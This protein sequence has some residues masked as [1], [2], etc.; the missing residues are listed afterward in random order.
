M[1]RSRTLSI[2]ALLVA[3]VG[4]GAIGFFMGRAQPAVQT[5]GERAVLY[6]YDPMAPDTHFDKPGK[7]PFMDMDLV[8]RYADERDAASGVSIAPGVV[9]NLGI[10]LATVERKDS[11]GS[12]RASGTLVYNDRALA[13]VQARVDGFVER[14][15]GRAVGDV[16][17]AGDAL[18]DIRA[19]SWS[20]AI[21]EYLS[22]RGGSDTLLAE[23]S[24]RRLSA[25]GIP[26][27]T[28]SASEASGAAPSTFTVRAPSSGAL[29]ALDAR[30]G[31]ALSAG[32]PIASISGLSP[33][34]LVVAVP[35]GSIGPLSTGASASVRFAA[36]PN[37]V[38]AGRIEAILPSANIA[39]RTIEVRVSLD[40]PQGQLRPG[41]TGDVTLSGE[42]AGSA[43]TVPSEAVIRTGRRNLVIVATD[44]GG[45][46]PVEVELGDALGDR[47]AIVAGLQ[48]GQ[49]VVAS[50]QFLID[51]E[52]NLTGVLARLRGAMPTGATDVYESTGQVTAIT[53]AGVTIA[54]A[55]IAKLNW[56]QMTMAFGWGEVARDVSVGD[57]VAF[58]FRKEGTAYVLSAIRKT[59]A[60][61]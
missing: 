44:G 26:N 54:H 21:A 47:M 57:T 37:E 60:P 43:L 11:T 36:V 34:W 18:V 6:W 39:N 16:V 27:E 53:H 61:R 56:P 35:Q 22:L 3:L 2:A 30:P 13:T 49:R 29:V 42:T 32:A 19:P 12:V 1:T 7:S 9:Q 40:N 41:M 52:A 20:A 31:S 45:F 15:R 8:P 10:R 5:Q 17:R 38:F 48:D 50:G 14:G 55:P 24:R 33:V 25:L 51:S 46:E 58:S 4:V 23:A 28:I 59:G